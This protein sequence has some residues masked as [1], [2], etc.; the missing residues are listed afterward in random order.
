MHLFLIRH[1]EPDIAPGICYGRLEMPARAVA[2][3]AARLRAFL[4]A[5]IPLWSS[6][7]RRCQ[8]L[9]EALHVAPRFDARLLEMHFGDW[10]GRPWAAIERTE[11]DAW[12]ANPCDF[13]PP[14]GESAR[15]V[16]QRAMEFVG[17]LRQSGVERAAVV[18]H[19][20][21]IRMLLSTA[22]ERAGRHPLPAAPAWGS[23]V[24]LRARMDSAGHGRVSSLMPMDS[25]V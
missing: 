9:A 23:G 10:E 15:Q 7:A 20:G 24:W 3:T 22:P 8:E 5:E 17:S 6:P 2:A 13:A 12:A 19:G 1:P 21:V 16:W 4:P 14:G 18:T 25:P 11:I